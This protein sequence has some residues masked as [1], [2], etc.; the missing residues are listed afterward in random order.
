MTHPFE[1]ELTVRQQFARFGSHCRLFAP[2]YRQG[3]IAAIAGLVPPADFK[4]AYSDVLSAFQHYLAT[5]NTAA[6]SC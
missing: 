4:H 6:A 2:I 3:T 5:W 1:E